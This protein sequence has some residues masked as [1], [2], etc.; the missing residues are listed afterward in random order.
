MRFLL[1][2]YPRDAW[3]AH[4]GFKEKTRLWFGAHQMFRRVSE[5]VKLD[6][7]ALINKDMT[8]GDY[9]GRLGAQRDKRVCQLNDSFQRLGLNYLLTQRM[10]AFRRFCGKTTYCWRRK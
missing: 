8:L 3:D 5:R 10:S 1:D 6:A 9:A 4:P 2:Q 7:E